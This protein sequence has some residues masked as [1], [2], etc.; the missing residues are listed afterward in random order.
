MS[1]SDTL[2]EPGTNSRT[3]ALG[4]LTDTIC[5]KSIKVISSSS[6]TWMGQGQTVR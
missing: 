1:A 3:C 6:F 2:T 5:G 4:W